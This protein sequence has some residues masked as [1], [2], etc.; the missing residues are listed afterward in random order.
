MR[1]LLFVLIVST[2][3]L[4]GLTDA[5]ACGDKTLRVG[6]GTRF[7]VQRAFAAR[8]PSAILIQ[9]SA[10][11]AGKAPLLRDYLQK[12]GHRPE[13]VEDSAH[14]GEAVRSGRYDLVLTDLADADDLRRQVE[15]SSFKTAVVPVM[16]K[17]SKGEVAAAARQYKV[18]VKNATSGDDFLQAVYEV[19]HSKAH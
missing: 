16:F 4:S 13:V 5:D 2:V 8:H 11:P 9:A 7:Q 12:V 3:V 10:I 15:S 17:R 19:M 6:R 18:I 1:R 14:L